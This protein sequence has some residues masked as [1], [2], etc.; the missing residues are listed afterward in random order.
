MRKF[1]IFLALLLFVGLQGVLAQ[2][3]IITG[4]VTSSEDKSPIPGVTVV[5]K[6]TTIGT[7]T[8]VDGK[9]VLTVPIKDNIL[10][11]SYVGMKTKE[12]KI[13]ESV[14]I[15]MV[16]ESDILNMN[17][18]VV[19]AIGIPRETKALS[20]S[21]QNLGASDINKTAQA[22]VINTI[23]GKVSDVQVI[24]SAGVA[25]AASYIQIRGV[26]SL[27]GN[28]QP[29]F[30]IDGVPVESGTSGSSGGGGGINNVDG[31]AQGNRAMDINPD[32]I[33]SISV[34][35]GGAATALYGLRA[36]SG[37]VIITTKKGHSTTGKKVS[38]TFNSSL[39][40][41]QVSK[42]PPRQNAYSQGSGG[43]WSSGNRLAWGAKIDTCALSPT[44]TNPS[45]WPG[46]DIGGSIVS[47]NRA[48]ATGGAVPTYDPYD[49]FQTGVTT[50]N[51][52]SLLG[53]SDISNF[54]FSFSDNQQKG[55]VPQNEYR[56]NTFKLSGESKLSEKFKI[57]GSANYIITTANRIQQGSNTSGVMLGLL[58]TPCTF[59]N[60]AGYLNP[61]PVAHPGLLQRSYRHGVGYDNPY[62]TANMNSYKDKTNRLIGSAEAYYYATKWLTFTYRIGVD[63]YSTKV[64]D[65]L[66]VGSNTQPAGW[67]RESTNITKNFNQDIFLTIDKDFAKD[68]NLHF[69]FGNNMFQ[70]NY[71]GLF[72]SANGLIIPEYYDL[73]NSTSIAASTATQAFR[74][75][76]FYGDLQLSWKSMVYLSL[77]GRNDWSTTLPEGKN[78]FFYPSVGAGFIF[79]QLDAIKDNKILPYGKIRVSYAIVAKD[80]P[81]YSTFT[82]YGPPVIAD[83]WT[84]GLTWPFQSTAGY[85]YG[86]IIINGVQYQQLGNNNLKPEKTQSFEI[87]TDLK[88]IQNRIGLSYTYF[89]NQGKDQILPVPI[90]T[91]SG[92]AQI[93]ENAGSIQTT[94]HEI[95][96]DVVP[97]KS[98]DW[99]WDITVNFAA[100]KNK[101]TA[102]A[103]G[104]ENLFLGGFTDPQ[105]RAVVGQPYRSIFG[106]DW[107]RDG[108]GKVI[109]D[110]K[111]LNDDGT[112]NTNYGYPTQDPDMK[113]L[114]N[115]DPDWTMGIGST[116][117]WRD[118]SL[119]VL[120]DIKSGGKMWDGT[121]GVMDYFGT[122]AGTLNRDDNYVFDGVLASNGGANN[123]NVKLD[124]SWRN[125]A[126]SG[127]SGPSV[128]YIENSSWVRLRTLTLSY[129]LT[130]LLKKTFIKGLEVYFTGTNLWLDT[131]YKGIDPE[132]NLLGTS[133]AQ[134][135]DYFNM[136]GTKSY[137]LGLQLAF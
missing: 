6:G 123:I 23:Q 36:A 20:Y 91:S 87:G 2:T 13:G 12:F 38:V 99:Q 46:F 15:D 132:T 41:D 34:L 89:N 96:L 69:T 124:Q 121:R 25:G 95:T 8:N 111:K 21:V 68:F 82:A 26:Q 106:F 58:R 136:P 86:V 90:A 32:D 92:Y 19:T 30:V 133:N 31:V 88:F 115:V 107:M 126:G 79:T 73:N 131:P 77:T 59:D 51:S 76:G 40:F 100:L 135:M 110:D 130:K 42:L 134:G 85:G 54:Y 24:S 114:G 116:L 55:V 74:T 50:N 52:I 113:S 11:F 83:G 105:I 14:T 33:E 93:V 57:A 18:V 45:Y 43:S 47:A 75:A 98:K 120:F 80:A 117:R 1:T 101:V 28:N 56:R 44:S 63:W 71:N 109:I 48:D 67:N 78:S 125:G 119:Y 118:L 29:L 65:Q 9:Y 5:V 84:T 104:I 7:T 62:W 66:A 97:I 4:T 61:D 70:S 94:G 37:A 112:I 122:S 72:T 137:T 27:N 64:N 35:K 129:S 10:V 3:R 81:A 60:S 103:P 127:F 49:F 17:E 128:D 16:M 39:Q 22:D 108:N 102:L 53:G